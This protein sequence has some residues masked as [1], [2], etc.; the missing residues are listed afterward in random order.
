MATVST[1]PKCESTALELE[2]AGFACGDCDWL[3][4]PETLM[5]L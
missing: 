1:C 5:E 3:A 2:P 4:C